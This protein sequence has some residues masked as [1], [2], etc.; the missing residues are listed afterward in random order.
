MF[1]EIRR[2]ITLFNTLI[3]IAF[4]LLFILL[5]VF[6]IQWSFQRSGEKALINAAQHIRNENLSFYE[7]KEED[8][9]KPA[10]HG[11]IG[12]EFIVWDL[13]GNADRMHIVNDDLIM[14]G[15]EL[16]LDTSF[17]NS[18]KTFKTG[19]RTYR[20]YS[21]SYYDDDQKK[22]IQVFQ[23]IDTEQNV[24]SYLVFF[25]L[26]I[27]SGGILLLIPISYILAGKSLQP[28]K[29]TFE[30]QKKF[31]ADASHELRTPLTVIQT[32]VEVLR[33]KED[34]VLA[35]NIKWLNN[36]GNESESMSKLV[37]QLLT[38]AQSDN[39]K[40][41]FEK[42]LFDL[43]ALCAE[44]IDLM[45]DV[46]KDKNI[47]LNGEI[48]SGIDYEGDEEKLKQAIRILVDNAIK[49][50]PSG[51]RV[52]LILKD[53]IRFVSVSVKDTG[54]GLSPEDQKKIF[55]RFYRVDDARNRESG[56][57]GLGLNIADM[58][59]KHHGGRIKLQ[60]VPDEG[61]TFTIVLPK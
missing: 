54:V 60:S 2:Q 44:I 38:I 6:L 52:D 34:E 39:N 3:L 51:G 12:T 16:S 14:E 11:D 7:D 45:V 32:N 20:V 30:N 59:V 9:D 21:A 29:E 17:N 37:S 31:I 8:Y 40:I 24:I 28:I 19:D 10:F 42:K 26:F 55:S 13:N 18:F 50:T 23:E 27:G 5:L 58:A 48:E 47:T 57:F 41:V 46:A 61:S 1:K 35:D 49:Y 36:I 56:G 43:S 25:L 33:L 53:G 22:I 4:L 15:Y